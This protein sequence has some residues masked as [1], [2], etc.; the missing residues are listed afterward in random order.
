[1]KKLFFTLLSFL[2]I[3]SIS[4]NEDSGP[5]DPND[6]EGAAADVLAANAALAQVLY[7]LVNSDSIQHPSDIDFTGPYNLYQTAYNKD[8]TNL[9]ANFGLAL[10]GILTISQ[11]Q[12]VIDAFNEWDSYLETGNPFEA[13]LAG[14]GKTG[15]KVGFPSSINYFNLHENSIAKT[16]LGTQKLAF[17]NPPKL[18]T[19]QNIFQNNLIP[20]L[21]TAL[22]ALDLVDNSPTYQFIIT[23]KMQGD[24]GEDDLEIDLTEIYA[25][26]VALN[27]LHS[28]VDIA[29][30]Y[31]VDF[32][33]YDSLG[34]LNAF[35]P[36]STFLTVRNSG[37]SL[38]DAKNAI[39]SAVD[40]IELG[41]NFLRNETDSQNDDI[42]KIGPDD[43]D[44]ADLDSILAHTNDVRDILNTGYTFHE[45]WDDDYSTPEEDLTINLGKFFDNPIQ[46]MKQKIPTYTVTVGRDTIDYSW[47]YDWGD[48][49]VY[50]NVNIAVGGFHTYYR[51]YN[52]GKDW[53]EYL[54]D[55]TTFSSHEFTNAFKTKILEIKSNPDLTSMYVSIYWSGYLNT[56]QNNIS[57][58]LYWN[59]NL[60][61]PDYAIYVPIFTWTANNFN[62]WIFPDPTF[63]GILPGMTDSEFKRIFGITADGW[64][65][66]FRF[67]FD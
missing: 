54:Y 43:I 13:P 14:S 29:I 52:W 25:M 53:G 50:S 55:D 44:H 31:D 26:E 4:C 65:K 37:S 1:M 63:N 45:D 16:V 62:S 11:D 21:N 32:T 15:L 40:K 38:A 42:I 49:L 7:D 59:Y 8:N 33:D 67:E 20:K 36:G 27:V 61:Y 47:D 24:L 48:S 30:A 17:Q 66:T 57:D 34:V 3:F 35:T 28:L 46:D 60:E 18:S 2:V 10:T 9:D 58:N 19:I 56:G 12:Q 64:Q 6:P 41:I 39:L 23:G 22:T 5:T 51:Y